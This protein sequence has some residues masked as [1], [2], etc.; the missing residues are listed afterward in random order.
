MPVL[1]PLVLIL[2]VASSHVTSSLTW[3]A[4]SGCPTED[5]VRERLLAV[6]GPERIRSVNI[7][8]FAEVVAE[9]Q[10]FLLRGHLIVDGRPQILPN[11][12]FSDCDDTVETLMAQLSP[13]YMS[14]PVQESNPSRFDWRATLRTGGILDIGEIRPSG[15]ARSELT[16]GGALALGFQRRRLRPELGV[17]YSF[18]RSSHS[19]LDHSDRVEMRWNMLSVQPRMCGIVGS[20]PNVSVL[21]CGTVELDVLWT[22][23]LRY[24]VGVVR[25][26]WGAVRLGPVVTWW[27]R[28]R[29]GLWL[30]VEPALRIFP[31]AIR[32]LADGTGLEKRNV[33]ELPHFS[34]RIGLGFE[35]RLGEIDR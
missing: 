32:P 30:A 6:F 16:A 18:A 31:W 11:I 19:M 8:T 35:L 26:V 5:A 4:P 28:P 17:T 14:I 23:N 2:G 20:K 21:V 22:G 27:V 7:Y 15:T 10:I 3:R 1:A 33:L 34:G 9:E 25:A 13:V 24:A 12:P 29:L